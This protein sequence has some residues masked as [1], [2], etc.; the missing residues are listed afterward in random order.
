VAF[1]A[2]KYSLTNSP[3]GIRRDVLPDASRD[4]LALRSSPMSATNRRC[5]LTVVPRTVVD[6]GAPYSSPLLGPATIRE[7]ATTA[8]Q[9]GL[10]KTSASGISGF[11]F[12]PIIAINWAFQGNGGRPCPA[13]FFLD[14]FGRPETLDSRL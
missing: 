14:V 1:R 5:T 10:R 2:I 4:V 11:D 3:G 8:P 12:S 9:F 13:I 7:F 6:L